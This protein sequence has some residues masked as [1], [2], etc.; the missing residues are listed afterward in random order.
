MIGFS[1]VVIYFQT[2]VTQAGSMLLVADTMLTDAYTHWILASFTI[3]AG[4]LNN[5]FT[6]GAKVSRQSL[7]KIKKSL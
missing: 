7:K 4:M 6:T 1:Y 3:A 5:T 2:A